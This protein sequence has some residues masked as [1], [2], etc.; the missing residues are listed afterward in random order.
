MPV[1][2]HKMLYFAGSSENPYNVFENNEKILIQAKIL[3]VL[4]EFFLSL[5]PTSVYQQV[6]FPLYLQ[7]ISQVY[8]FISIFPCSPLPLQSSRPPSLMT[9]VATV[10]S[11]M[12]PLSNLAQYPRW[13]LKCPAECMP[14]V[15]KASSGSEQNLSC[16]HCVA[17]RQRTVHVE[18]K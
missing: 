10:S 5:T 12:L 9:S 15:F 17:G 7:R 3:Q 18:V 8:P 2:C 4:Y 1:G 11:P 6:L 16:R 13:S 14:A